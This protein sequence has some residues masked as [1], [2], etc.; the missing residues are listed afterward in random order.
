MYYVDMPSTDEIGDLNLMRSEACISIYLPTSPIGREIKQSRTHLNT[1]VKQAISQL[2]KTGFDKRQ[3]IQALQDKFADLLADDEFWEHQANS[4][5][6]LATPE[7]LHTFRL[8]N[9]LTDI[10]E[11]SDR[12]HLKPLLRA[13]TFSHSAHILA[14]SENAVRLIELSP[15]LP[16][17]VIEVPNLPSDAAEATNKLID[18]DFKGSGHRPSGQSHK[19]YLTNYARKVNTALRP[20]LMQSQQPL[21]LAATQPLAAL[22]RSLSSTAILP[23]IITGNPEHLSETQLAT[24]ARPLLDA[25]YAGIIANFHQ[26]FDT[27]TSQN[28]TTTDIS[29]A[30]R[31]ATFGGIEQLLVDI[32]GVVNGFVDDET[33]EVIFDNESDAMNYGIVDEITCR[34]FRTGAKVMAVRKQDIPGGHDLAVI[35]RYP[36]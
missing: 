28:R 36:V 24:A 19:A 17:R 29:S 5:A 1:L 20:L 2:E 11:V 15:D 23:N 7:S 27:R 8:A 35:A 22:F 21:L 31:L 18:K 33:G 13:I 26:L 32:D 3:H 10:V 30:A 16:P 25:H 9:K 6:I 4:L 14:L 12:F 34:A